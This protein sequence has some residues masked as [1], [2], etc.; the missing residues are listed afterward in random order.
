MSDQELIKEALAARERAYAPYS[1]FLVGAALL[2]KSG[3]V[4]AGCNV[5]NAS[6][7]LTICAERVAMGTAVSAGERE[8]EA[9][10]IA[11]KGG[12][13]PCGACRQ[14]L[15]EF[16]PELRVLMS[17][18]NG[19]LVREMSLAELLPESFGPESL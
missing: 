9:I 17:D 2:G 16:A 15:R 6:Y 1:E 11:V 4:Y 8:F 19:T 10:A 13:S 5:E 18:E 14:V 12:G 7:G 3:K